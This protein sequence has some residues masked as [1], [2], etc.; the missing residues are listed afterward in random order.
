MPDMKYSKA[1]E[2]LEDIIYGLHVGNARNYLSTIVMNHRAFFKEHYGF[3]D[4]LGNGPLWP[5]IETDPPGLPASRSS[6]PRASARRCST[7]SSRSTMV[8]SQ[9]KSRPDTVR[10]RSICRRV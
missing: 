6:T 10:K 8:L 5:S 1:M 7:S 4:G 2:R 3:A 9:A